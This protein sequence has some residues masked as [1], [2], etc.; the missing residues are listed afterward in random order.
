[1]ALLITPANDRLAEG[2]HVP[3]AIKFATQW[4]NGH[5]RKMKEIALLAGRHFFVRVATTL[6]GGNVR[7]F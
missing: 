2:W 6:K 4:Q 5:N 7:Q 3:G 1:M